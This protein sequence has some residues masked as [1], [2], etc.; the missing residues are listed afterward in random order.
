MFQTTVEQ[1]QLSLRTLNCLK[2][3]HLNMGAMCSCCRK[4]NSCVSYGLELIHRKA[5]ASSTEQLWR[6][7]GRI[8]ERW[9]S[10]GYIREERGGM[11]DPGYN[12]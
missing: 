5:M 3:A 11:L 6:C 12:R 8:A 2:R 10:E 7:L 4:E 9:R 1:L